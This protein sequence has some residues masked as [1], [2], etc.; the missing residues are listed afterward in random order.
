M[1]MA[2]RCVPR[3]L[4][5]AVEHAGPRGQPH[6][7]QV[8]AVLGRTPVDSRFGLRL[9]HTPPSPSA[10]RVP[11]APRRTTCHPRAEGTDAVVACQQ[12]GEGAA[13][14]QGTVAPPETGDG[15]EMVPGG[16][17]PPLPT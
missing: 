3:A 12:F 4:L 2:A 7:K 1:R 6:S 11:E 16:I 13:R 17:E 15:G 10:Q 9:R 14:S 8:W 5:R